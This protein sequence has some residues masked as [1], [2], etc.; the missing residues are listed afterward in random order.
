MPGAIMT[1]E[2]TLAACRQHNAR[3]QRSADTI[4]ACCAC[5]VDRLGNPIPMADSRREH[6]VTEMEMHAAQWDNGN[7]EPWTD[8]ALADMIV[9][10]NL[11]ETVR[12]YRE[13]ADNL[14]AEIV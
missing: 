3:L 8:E 11:A 9:E 13:C 10:D 5:L 12:F 6:Y 1:I 14:V 7:R 2:S 4:R